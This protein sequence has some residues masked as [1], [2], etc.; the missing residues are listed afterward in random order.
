MQCPTSCTQDSQCQSG[1]YCDNTGKCAGSCV[2]V[3]DVNCVLTICVVVQS[4][5]QTTPHA[6]HSQSV[7][8]HTVPLLLHENAL[9]ATQTHNA[10]STINAK[11]A[12]AHVSFCCLC[13][14]V[15]CVCV[16]VCVCV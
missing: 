11:T 7:G 2:V 6:L 3:R 12:F 4:A 1:H 10:K 5:G 14:C 9:H 16:P 8:A 13:V 15:V